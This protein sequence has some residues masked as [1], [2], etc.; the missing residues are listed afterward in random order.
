MTTTKKTAKPDLTVVGKGAQKR[1]QPGGNRTRRLAA[2]QK[3]LDDEARDALVWKEAF[4]GKEYRAIAD[5]FGWASPSSVHDAIQRHLSRT[6]EPEVERIRTD[7]LH[8]LRLS[9]AW[10]L[11]RLPGASD[12]AGSRLIGALVQ[13]EGRIAA[14]TGA[15]EPRRSEVTGYDGGP[16]RVTTEAEQI[17]SLTIL[18]AELGRRLAAVP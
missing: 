9:R 16:I 8:S 6:P 15:D 17:E 5:Q 14:L 11:S 3:R 13:I 10:I 2:E 18:H 7:A 1:T 12:T 4:D